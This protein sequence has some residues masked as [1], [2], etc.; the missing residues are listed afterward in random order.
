[1]SRLIVVLLLAAVASI[2]A[3]TWQPAAGRELT[4]REM[5]MTFGGAIMERCVQM[6][7]CV[8]DPNNCNS[9]YAES[10]EVQ[11]LISEHDVEGDSKGKECKGTYIGWSCTQSGWIRCRMTLYCE[12]DDE[13][14][15]CS[16][17]A[18]PEGFKSDAD[19]P[20]ECN[21]KQ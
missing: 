11:C 19:G 21:E 12:W 3:S 4:E 2:T 7:T 13:D 1:M 9:D 20:D 15:E 18:F 5:W 8:I 17:K 10:G 16:Q 6:S 14:D